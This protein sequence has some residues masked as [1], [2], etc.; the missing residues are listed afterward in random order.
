MEDTK[1]QRKRLRSFKGPGWG[2]SEKDWDTLK[3]EVLLDIKELLGELLIET[4]SK[5]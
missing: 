3:I 5:K 4:R 1:E 2:T